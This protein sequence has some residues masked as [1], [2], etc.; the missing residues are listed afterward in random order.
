MQFIHTFAS[1]ICVRKRCQLLN[2]CRKHWLDV[3]ILSEDHK[4]FKTWCKLDFG[5]VDIGFF[6][7]IA[8]MSYCVKTLVVAMAFTHDPALGSQV[9]LAQPITIQ[10]HT[11][12]Q[13]HG[14]MIYIL[15]I[16]WFIHLKC[17]YPLNCHNWMNGC[18]L[19]EVAFTN[20]VSSCS[21]PLEHIEFYLPSNLSPLKNSHMC[22][23]VNF[24]PLILLTV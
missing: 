2:M 6:S 8:L 17:H 7:Y 14:A 1:L 13:G 5:S 22:L 20:I 10:M 16:G 18:A 15:Q 19:V 23:L 3:S 24:T 11:L 21:M 9:L 12:W 4:E